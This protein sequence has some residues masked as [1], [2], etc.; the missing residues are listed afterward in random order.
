MYSDGKNIFICDGLNKDIVAAVTTLYQRWK[1]QPKQLVSGIGGSDEEQKCEAVFAYMVE[2][3]DYLLDPVGK[4]LIKSPAR[5]LADGNG[6]CKSLTMFVSCC[7]HCLGISHIIRFV[8]FDGDSQYTHVYPVALLKDG[9]E[10]ILDMCE[11]DEDGM[12]LY[13]YARPYSKKRD[14]I[15]Y[16]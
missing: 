11:T 12:I 13:D 5:L 9:R 16:E 10:V 14:F 7:L 6:D 15:Y 8:S 2:H 3:V 1:D 4:Q